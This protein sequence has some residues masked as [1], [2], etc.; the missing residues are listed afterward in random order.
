MNEEQEK[1]ATEPR[2]LEGKDAR[3]LEIAE[4]AVEYSNGRLRIA[5]QEKNDTEEFVR[6]AQRFLKFDGKRLGLDIG[7]Y[8]YKASLGSWDAVLADFMLGVIYPL[9]DELPESYQKAAE[10][11]HKFG[12]DVC[13]EERLDEW[14]EAIEPLL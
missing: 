6:D 9:K 4:T 1:Y 8:C 14:D 7:L 5:F 10:E 11:L 13:P 3:L 2:E 12:Q